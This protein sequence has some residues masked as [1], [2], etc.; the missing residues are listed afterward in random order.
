MA[1]HPTIIP[2]SPRSPI[3]R[4]V[5]GIVYPGRMLD[6]IRLAAAGKF[7]RGLAGDARNAHKATLICAAVVSSHRLRGAL[8]A[9]NT[10][11]R[12]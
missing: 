10:G 1:P 3:D 5:K 12:Q 2:G 7:A 6:K 4:W 11:R 9:G 8:E